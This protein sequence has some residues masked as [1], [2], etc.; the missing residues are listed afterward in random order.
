MTNYP[1]NTSRRFNSASNHLKKQYGTR[2]QKVAID[3]GFTCPNRDGSKS[4]GGCTFCGNEAFNPSYCNPE[5]SL[6][7]QMKEGI[8]FHARRYRKAKKYLAYFQAYSNTYAPV[9]QLRKLYSEVLGV[10]NVVGMVIG[11]RPDCF[12]ESVADLLCELAENAYIMV[13]FGIESVYNSSLIKVNRCHSFEDSVKAINLCA[14]KG[15]SCGGHIIFGLPGETTEMMLDSARIV[16]EL[17]LASL[18]LHQLQ[19][20]KGTQMGNEYLTHPQL[21]PLFSLEEYIDLISRYLCYLRPD[22]IIERLAAETQPWIN[23][24]QKWTLR[25]DRVLALIEEKMEKD[26]LWQGKYYTKA[27]KLKA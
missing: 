19:L 8:E 7:Q 12:D 1:W 14:E 20:I 3:A 13:E 17:P 16:S 24:K 25:Y 18:K 11:T 26:N 27:E 10:E 15:I 4:T 6:T 9:E 21:F 5:K 23:L 2:L 22:I